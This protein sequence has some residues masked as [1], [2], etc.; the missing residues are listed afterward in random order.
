M[1]ELVFLGEISL[2]VNLSIIRKMLYK[3]LLI[4]KWWYKYVSISDTFSA[5][6]FLSSNLLSWLVG[7][8]SARDII[9]CV[10]VCVYKPEDRK[11]KYMRDDNRLSSLPYKWKPMI[12]PPAGETK[13][14]NIPSTHGQHWSHK[15]TENKIILQMYSNVCLM[16]Q[17]TSRDLTQ[18]A[19]L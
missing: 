17:W 10:S 7:S 19:H 5:K 16:Q 8:C 6:L 9:K 4:L 12:H 15:H 3:T 14:T 1:T 18:S 11:R 13:L 2:K